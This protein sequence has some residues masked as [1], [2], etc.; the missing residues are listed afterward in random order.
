MQVIGYMPTKFPLIGAT[1]SGYWVDCVW[2]I[3]GKRQSQVFNQDVLIKLG[4]GYDLPNYQ[5][6]AHSR[7]NY[8]QY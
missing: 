2:D 1:Q 6:T 5:S 4:H 3:N 8:L 7:A